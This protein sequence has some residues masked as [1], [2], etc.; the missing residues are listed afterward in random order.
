GKKPKTLNLLTYKFHALGDYILTIRWFRTTDS[1]STQM[2]ELGHRTSKASY[3]HT[4]KN[5][6]TK[7]LASI[8]R[9]QSN[10]HHIVDARKEVG[11]NTG[12]RMHH[13]DLS[14][15]EPMS[16]MSADTHHHVATSQKNPVHIG[17]WIRKNANDPALKV[18]SKVTHFLVLAHNS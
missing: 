16:N 5:N 2:P 14:E 3:P 10:L 7:Q 18:H 1:Y 11:I 6:P 17:T 9:H 13:L 12:Y 4:S 15:S 8:E